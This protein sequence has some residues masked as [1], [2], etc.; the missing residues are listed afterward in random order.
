MKLLSSD[1]HTFAV[2]DQPV[3]GAAAVNDDGEVK[4]CANADFTGNDTVAVEITDANDHDRKV[5]VAIPV[6]VTAGTP[7]DECSIEFGGGCCSAGTPLTAGGAA[8]A[9]VVGAVL[10]RRR[11]RR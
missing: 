1:D 11:R 6:A 8:P 3:S 9:I 4:Y 5:V 7:D 2:R 10:L